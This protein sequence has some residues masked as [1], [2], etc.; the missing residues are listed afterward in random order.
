MAKYTDVYFK[1]YMFET[2]QSLYPWTYDWLRFI[3]RDIEPQEIYIKDFNDIIESVELGHPQDTVF[4]AIYL[5]RSQF[6]VYVDRSFQKIDSLLSYLGG[7][8]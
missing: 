2:D 5:R 8:L 3:N 6:T 4:S 1:K 7:F